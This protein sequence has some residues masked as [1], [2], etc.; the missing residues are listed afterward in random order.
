MGRLIGAGLIS[1]L[2]LGFFFKW[3]QAVTGKKVFLLL[4]NVDYIPFLK[5]I[6]LS[7]TEEFL[8]HLTV[9]IPLAVF[10]LK[11]APLLSPQKSV[12][13][14]GLLL[15]SIF[16]GII[17]YPT[18]VLSAR[19]PALSDGQAFFWWIGGHFFYGAALALFLPRR[20]RDTSSNQL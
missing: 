18:T 3:I 4:L 6:P 17:L 15:G 12:Q 11:T 9:S 1:G 2:I 5:D 7:E 20:F 10:L 13:A 14:A 19:T 8:L 16:I